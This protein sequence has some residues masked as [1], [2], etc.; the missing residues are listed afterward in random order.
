MKNDLAEVAWE[1][2]NFIIMAQDW[3]RLR[4][5]VNTIHVYR[6]GNLLTN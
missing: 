6:R 3:N 2:V 1:D 5:R 4:A